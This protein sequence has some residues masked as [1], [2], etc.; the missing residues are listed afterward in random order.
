MDP[1]QDSANPLQ[2]FWLTWR[3]VILLAAGSTAAICVAIVLLVQTVQTSTPIEFIGADTLGAETG[4]EQ[5]IHIDIEGAVASPGAKTLPV[6]SRV[7]DALTAAGGFTLDA[8]REYTA[9][10]LNRAQPLSDGMKIYVPT[11]QEYETSHNL[12]AQTNAND[13]SHNI[14]DTIN[15]QDGQVGPLISINSATLAELDTLSGVGLVTAQKI[16]SN[17]PYKTLEDLVNKKVIGV[18]LFSRIRSRLAL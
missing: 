8:D 17:R 13:T 7:E 9:K 5:G 18:S 12:G 3:W 16:L 4:G 15:S 14:S 2:I 11:T 6:G 10:V 1:A